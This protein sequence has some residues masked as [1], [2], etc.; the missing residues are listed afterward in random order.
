MGSKDHVILF[1][2]K[3]YI[4]ILLLAIT[5]VGNATT[6]ARLQKKQG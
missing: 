3:Y 6:T 2:N 1:I 4:T 5:A